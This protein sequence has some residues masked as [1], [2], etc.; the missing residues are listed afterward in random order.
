MHA[1]SVTAAPLRTGVFFSFTDGDCDLGTDCL[2]AAQMPSDGTQSSAWPATPEPSVFLPR[3]HTRRGR[4]IVCYWTLCLSLMLL[5]TVS[6]VHP[7][8]ELESHSQVS[9]VPGTRPLSRSG[10]SHFAT[11]MGRPGITN[12]LPL[13]PSAPSL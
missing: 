9:S 5:D 10:L 12:W 7:H 11:M 8:A 1:H 6:I 4:T 2:R 3:S 13:H